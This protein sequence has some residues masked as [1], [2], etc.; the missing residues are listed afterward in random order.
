[1]PAA[2]YIFW[3][4]LCWVLY[5]YLLYPLLLF[6]AA[7][8]VQLRSDARQAG[9]G[10]RRQDAVATL[11]GLSVIL[12][13]RNEAAVLPAKLANLA[14]LDYPPESLEFIL[15]SDGSEDATAALLAQWADPRARCL[16]LPGHQGKAAAINAAVAVARFPVLLFCDAATLLE[17]AA[18]RRLAAHFADPRVGVACGTLRFRASPESRRTEGVYWRFETALRLL[19]ARLGA[20]LTPSGALYALRRA[21]F[22][23]LPADALLDDLLLLWTARRLGYRAVLDSGARGQEVAAATVGDEFHRRLRIAVGSFRAL[24][25]CWRTPM[26]ASTR[27]AFT[28]HKVMRWLTPWFALGLL[29]SS[30]ALVAHPAFR[31]VLAGQLALYLW[32]LVGALARRRWAHVPGALLPYFGV[33]MQLALAL[34]LCRWLAGRLGLTRGATV[35]WERA[36]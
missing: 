3:L 10:E 16:I 2:A 27:W 32:A 17:P 23:P 28:S 13:A 4:C 11:T 5:T 21:A 35:R 1:M 30:L 22:R 15:A 14:K 26:T 12:V 34:G 19:E 29:A 24:P 25:A 18:P 6:L 33:A 7:A 20:T 8:S 36:R 9:G 31:L